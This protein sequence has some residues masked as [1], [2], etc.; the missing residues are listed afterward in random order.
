M[1]SA[2]LDKP[3]FAALSWC[4]GV[5]FHPM[6]LSHKSRD[7][8][9][10]RMTARGKTRHGCHSRAWPPRDESRFLSCVYRQPVRSRQETG[11]QSSPD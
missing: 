2:E 1:L 10:A 11:C 7:S 5:D 4:E 8:S 9:R 3:L 6:P